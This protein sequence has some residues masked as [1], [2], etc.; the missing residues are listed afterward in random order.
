MV[1][2]PAASGLIADQTDLT[3]K[4][5]GADGR[6][7]GSRAEDRGRRGNQPE[8]CA[9]LLIADGPADILEI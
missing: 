5:R 7:S 8:G 9:I 1:M 2:I 6:G 4:W 3:E